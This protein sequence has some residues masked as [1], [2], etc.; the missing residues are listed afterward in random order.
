LLA[1]GDG[2]GLLR[3]MTEARNARRAWAGG[4]RSNSDE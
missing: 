4:K 1:R 2:P 3:L